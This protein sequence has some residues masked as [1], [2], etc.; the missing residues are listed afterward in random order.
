M[1]TIHDFSHVMNAQNRV[2]VRSARPLQPPVAVPAMVYLENVSIKEGV[3]I[4]KHFD[5]NKCVLPKL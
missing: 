1:Q 2:R 4:E 5:I 3:H